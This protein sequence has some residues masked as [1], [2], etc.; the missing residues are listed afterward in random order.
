MKFKMLAEASRDGYDYTNIDGEAIRVQDDKFSFH[1]FVK[2]QETGSPEEILAKRAR[3]ILGKG[4]R[5][6]VMDILLVDEKTAR[7][8]LAKAREEITKETIAAENE[9]K[10]LLDK[11]RW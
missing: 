8:V 7:A 6:V 10:K 4:S 11:M 1:D 2:M 3:D 9:C 5:T